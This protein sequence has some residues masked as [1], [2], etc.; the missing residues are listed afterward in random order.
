[1]N[2]GP[3]HQ[4]RGD[5]AERP[6]PEVLRTIHHYRVPGVV[7]ARNGPEACKRLYVKDG[8]IIFASSTDIQDS[9]GCY[10][11]NT[12][13]IDAEQFRTTMRD[14]RASERRYGAI[15]LERGL[16]PA[17]DLYRAIRLQMAEILWSLFSWTEGKITFTVGDFREPSTTSIQIPIRLAIKDGTRRCGNPSALLDSVGG[18]TAV[19]EPDFALEDLIDVSL[20]AD[21]HV[22]LELVDG[23]R[24]VRQVVSEGPFDP[25]LNA[26]IIYAFFVLRLIRR[27]GSDDSSGAIRIRLSRG[28][29]K[30]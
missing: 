29:D 22:L 28:G 4:Y 18:A 26:R 17:S 13:M 21:E 15:V 9:L 23:V 6:L 10:M 3:I 20:R 12:G 24:T 16:V 19:L 27:P 25:D 11:L 8:N 30:F 2:P 1:M 7:E 14:R 5:L